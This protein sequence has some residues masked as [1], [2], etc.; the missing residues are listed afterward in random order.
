MEYTAERNL[1]SK[2]NVKEFLNH[3]G[4][5]HRISNDARTKALVKRAYGQTKNKSESNSAQKE[6]FDFCCDMLMQAEQELQ[7]I[8]SLTTINN[9]GIRNADY[10]LDSD[11][12]VLK[13]DVI[14]DCLSLNRED[15]ES[16]IKLKCGGLLPKTKVAFDGK[17]VIV[18]GGP[19]S[20]KSGF[21]RCLADSLG[22][23]TLDS[24]VIAMKLPE[25]NSSCV[26]ASLVHDEAK[27]ILDDIIAEVKTSKANIVMPIL[28]KKYSSLT[29]LINNL[30]LCG[31]SVYVMLVR[32]SKQETACRA[33]SRFLETKR[34][35]PL[36]Y[37]LDSC[38]N[39]SAVTFYRLAAERRDG[40]FLCIDN[41]CVN[42]DI[43]II[44]FEQNCEEIA[45]ILESNQKVQALCAQKA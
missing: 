17:A 26:G 45:S 16:K 37:V 41:E 3:I 44:E 25:Y 20:G 18:V 39:E 12:D 19:A 6:L 8:G 35:V 27:T 32:L 14:H 11:R 10:R 36:P 23:F 30:E 28:G 2:E 40:R 13:D 1:R 7:K 24:D 15:D 9:E 5:Y 38:G 31:Y 33:F 34:Y 42:S 21:C 22:A 4:Y 43:A 29:T